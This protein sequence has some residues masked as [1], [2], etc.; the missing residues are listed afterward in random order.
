MSR[1]VSVGIDLGA[2]VLKA[3]WMSSPNAEA[4]L[5]CLERG[6]SDDAEALR[7]IGA[8]LRLRGVKRALV[9]LV[10]PNQ[11]V[12]ST[13]VEVPSK[14]GQAPREVI[15]AGEYC[16]QL[17]IAPGSCEIRITELPEPTRKA[18]GDSV[19]VSGASREKCEE[20]CAQA[21]EAGLDV[22]Y[23]G[24]PSDAILASGAMHRRDEIATLVDVGWNATRVVVG[25]NGSI[26]LRRVGSELGLESVLSSVAERYGVEVDCLES[27]FVGGEQT[28]LI[29]EVA[30][31]AFSRWAMLAAEDVR[32]AM[33]YAHH[34]HSAFEFAPCVCVGGAFGIEALQAAMAGAA[35]F[36]IESPATGV[37]G[38]EAKGVA[39]L[40]AQ[41]CQ[42]GAAA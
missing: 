28:Q 6:G 40:V 22:V 42:R 37:M 16:R 15:A 38:L 35:P 1:T 4:E 36:A 32:A 29:E 14:G 34:R 7:R 24:T 9:G 12:R 20:L 18:A 5:I 27:L 2:R 41:A 23:I 31:G 26:V 30:A 21:A 25:L 13:V 17:G 11:S 10:A 39:G 8:S 19:L 3:A 33:S